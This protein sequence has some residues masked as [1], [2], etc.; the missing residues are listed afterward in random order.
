MERCTL[1]N[2][3]LISRCDDWVSRLAKSGG[4]EWN[5]NIP[6]DFNKD[7]DMLFNELGRRFK[8]LLLEDDSCNS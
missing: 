4:R 2:Q 8:A 5:L 7:P 1:S 3:E 6:V